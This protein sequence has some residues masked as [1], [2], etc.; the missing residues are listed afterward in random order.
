MI[1]TVDGQSSSGK[2]SL[3]F[4]LAYKL[5]YHFLGSGSIYR[6][7][8]YAKSQNMD[9]DEYILF[10]KDN[11]KYVFELGEMRVL[12]GK[13]DLTVELHESHISELASKMAKDK[14]L[15]DKLFVLQKSFNKSPGLV[16]EGRDMGTIVFPEAE[17]KFFLVSDIQ[18]RAERRLTQLKEMGIKRDIEDEIK[19]LEAR[20]YRDKNREVSPLIPHKD[21]ITIDTSHGSKKD[22]L[23]KMIGYINSGISP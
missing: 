13:E 12:V 17:I 9:I 21:A 2:S 16:A 22:N 20:D 3:A 5:N 7:V 18:I 1:I 14:K 6:L 15:R 10:L 8:A 11:L 4:A 23:N 19:Q